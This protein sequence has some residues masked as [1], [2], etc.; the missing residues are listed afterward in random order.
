MA[1]ST[2]PSKL[3]S[4]V[5]RENMNKVYRVG[6]FSQ[7]SKNAEWR[8]MWQAP[9]QD[10]LVACNKIEVLSQCPQGTVA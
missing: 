3:M 8:R 1:Q 9:C 4:I 10:R 5:E 2:H 7:G 6:I